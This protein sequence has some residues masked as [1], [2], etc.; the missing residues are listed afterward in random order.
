MVTAWA[1]PRQ[2]LE[3]FCK[4][5]HLSELSFFGSVVRP[6]FNAESDI[7]VIVDFTPGYVPG[8]AVA[9]MCRELEDIL[10]RPVDV[11][12]RVSIEYARNS[13]VKQAI[14]ATIVPFYGKPR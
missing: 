14:L 8:V 11:L 13:P 9:R 6:D 4:R 12:T 10:G 3:D 1:L 7:D 5:W 2:E